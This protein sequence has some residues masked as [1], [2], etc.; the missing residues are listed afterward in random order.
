[1]LT[2]VGEN[3]WRLESSGAYYGL[4]KRGRKQFR[5]SLKTNDRALAKRRL[6][7]LREDV[8]E[9]SLKE[10]GTVTFDPMAERWLDNV[11]HSIKESTVLRNKTCIKNGTPFFQGLGVQNI[12]SRHCMDWVT[13]RG[14]GIAPSTFAHELDTLRLIFNFAISQGLIL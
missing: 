1:M 6:A 9:L 5:R 4:L 3:L 10:N 11:R 2:N 14:V 8:A 12:T 7:E 13:K